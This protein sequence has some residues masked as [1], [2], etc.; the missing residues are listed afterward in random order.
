M[1][2]SEFLKKLNIL[3]TEYQ[4][5]NNNELPSIPDLEKFVKQKIAKNKGGALKSLKGLNF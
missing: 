5:I 3:K 2:L 1:D 4:K